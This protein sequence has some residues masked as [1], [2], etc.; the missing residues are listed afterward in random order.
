MCACMCVYACVYKH[1]YTC[2]HVYAYSL[3]SSPFLGIPSGSLQDKS[4]QK[5]RQWHF[6]APSLPQGGDT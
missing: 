2:V 4:V 1:M 6:P 5:P 3:E